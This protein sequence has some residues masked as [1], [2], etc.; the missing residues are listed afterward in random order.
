MTGSTGTPPHHLTVPPLPPRRKE[1]KDKEHRGDK[2]AERDKEKDRERRPSPP[3]T[4][5]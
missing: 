3:S 2:D 1:R 5:R 4:P